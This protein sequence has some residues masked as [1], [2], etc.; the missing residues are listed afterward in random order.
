MSAVST[1]ER[2]KDAI[3]HSRVKARTSIVNVDLN[4][5]RLPFDNDLNRT[6]AMALCIVNQV[7]NDPLESAGIRTNHRLVANNEGLR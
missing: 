3:S 6:R 5:I 4:L 1:S 2:L 7:A